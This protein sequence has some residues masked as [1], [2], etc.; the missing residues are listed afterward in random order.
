[1]L[2]HM[3]YKSRKDYAVAHFPSGFCSFYG[4][5]YFDWI[6]SIRHFLGRILFFFCHGDEDTEHG[7]AYIAY[8]CILV[9]SGEDAVTEEEFLIIFADLMG[10]YED[11]VPA[12]H[13]K[14]LR[15]RD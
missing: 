4:N 10:G 6:L 7:K 9:E 12:D 3:N 13:G 14:C 15:E 2:Y 5:R 8:I 1:M 11:V